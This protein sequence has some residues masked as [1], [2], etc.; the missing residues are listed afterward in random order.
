[1]LAERGSGEQVERRA[2]RAASS[3]LVSNGWMDIA[4]HEGFMSSEVKG[5]AGKREPGSR[6]GTPTVKIPKASM[7]LTAAVAQQRVV[8]NVGWWQ[9]RCTGR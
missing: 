9:T 1:M 4:G 7:G 2:G 5:S 6:P 3:V 8:T